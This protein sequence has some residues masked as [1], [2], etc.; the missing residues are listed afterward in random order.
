MRSP[1]H[2]IH[3]RLAEGE[4][5]GLAATS[6]ASTGCYERGQVVGTEQF[7]R[8]GAGLSG[9]AAPAGWAT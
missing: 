2:Q 7:L 5:S 4:P 1:R 6:L 9:L 3:G 8:S